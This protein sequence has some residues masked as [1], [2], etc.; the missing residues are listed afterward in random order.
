M[1]ERLRSGT[2]ESRMS[3]KGWAHVELETSERGKY[4]NRSSTDDR[5]KPGVFVVRHAEHAGGSQEA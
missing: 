3:S 2:R 1:M 4:E 5:G